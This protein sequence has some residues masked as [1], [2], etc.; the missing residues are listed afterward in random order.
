MELVGA[1]S[2][3]ERVSDGRRLM[4]SGDDFHLDVVGNVE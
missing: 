2:A 3:F 1:K 4:E